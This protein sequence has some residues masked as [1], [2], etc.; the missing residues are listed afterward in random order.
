[1]K[2]RVL[3]ILGLLVLMLASCVD[4]SRLGFKSLSFTRDGVNESPDDPATEVVVAV[5]VDS[6]KD[7]IPDSLDT[8]SDNDGIDNSTDTDDDNDGTD[9]STDTD[10]DNDGIDDNNDDNN[11]TVTATVTQETWP[12]TGTPLVESA[13]VTIVVDRSGSM[14]DNFPS[15]SE[16]MGQLGIKLSED[17]YKVC[18]GVM[19]GYGTANITGRLVAATGGDYC[20]CTDEYTPSQI[21]TIIKN[22]LNTVIYDELGQSEMQDYSTWYS[23]TNNDAIAFNQSISGGRCAGN[24][25]TFYISAGDESSLR[26]SADTTA[27]G[28]DCSA[29]TVDGHPLV[30]SK[31]GK[32]KDSGYACL[33]GSARAKLMSTWNATTGKFDTWF[34][35]QDMKNAFTSYAGIVPYAYHYIG[36]T[37]DQPDSPYEELP[38]GHDKDIAALGGSI[39][40]ILKA[41]SDSSGFVQDVVN[42]LA[43]KLKADLIYPKTFDVKYNVCKKLAFTVSVD[44]K[45]VTSYSSLIGDKRFSILAPHNQGSSVTFK[46]VRADDPACPA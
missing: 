34:D 25:G 1:M 23:L 9:D 26:E 46:Y 39:I 36:H 27:P 24:V 28:V 45:D 14:A 3:S 12:I 32:S 4:N 22:N 43:P 6:D 44:G 35:E 20:A 37:S 8:D 42:V 13:A 5:P 18:F 38:L 29:T 10:D 41:K 31:A 33:E 2:G 30:F 7:G 11:T 15:F 21:A 19:G 17:G 40:D 16:A